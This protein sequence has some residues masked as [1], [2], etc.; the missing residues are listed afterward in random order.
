M[1]CR[2]HRRAISDDLDGALSGRRRKGLEGHLR[3]CRSCREFEAG[4]R[5]MEERVPRSAAGAWTAA[6]GEDSLVRLRRRLEA[7]PPRAEAPAPLRKR[8]WAWASA[9]AT[10]AAAALV[11]WFLVLRPLPKAEVYLLSESDTFGAI[12]LEVAQNPELEKALDD[13]LQ[14][15][16]VESLKDG[17]ETLPAN[18]FENPLLS[19]GLSEEEMGALAEGNVPDAPK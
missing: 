14:S 17:G 4:L 10:V 1:S 13:I 11:A 12:D 6:R 7:E 15:S 2:R 9:G 19:E 18:P 5:A 16:I 8:W 3:S